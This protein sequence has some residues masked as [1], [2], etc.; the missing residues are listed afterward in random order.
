LVPF[1]TGAESW[2]FDSSPVGEIEAKRNDLY[3]ENSAQRCKAVEG[4][5][6]KGLPCN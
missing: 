3:S 5:A 4:V 6:T 2:S 1:Q